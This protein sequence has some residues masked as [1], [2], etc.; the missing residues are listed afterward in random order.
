MGLLLFAEEWIV[1][2]AAEAWIAFKA[3]GAWVALCY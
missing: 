1:F 2:D 3:D